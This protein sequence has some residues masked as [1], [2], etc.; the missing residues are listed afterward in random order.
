MAEEEGR[1]GSWEEGSG[2]E[3]EGGKGRGVEGTWEA[4]LCVC[5]MG[6]YV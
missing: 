2:E 4:H 6:V 3:V 1:E 5:V